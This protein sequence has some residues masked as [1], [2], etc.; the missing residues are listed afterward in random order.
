V[1]CWA[2]GV[3]DTGEIFS[4]RLLGK[5]REKAPVLKCTFLV[6]AS[7]GG[8]GPPFRVLEAKRGGD[9]L[10]ETRP[11]RTQTHV[12]GVG[13]RTTARKGASGAGKAEVGRATE[14][15][16]LLKGKVP[17]T[18]GSRADK[19]SAGALFL[20]AQLGCD[21]RVAEQV[22][23]KSSEDEQKKAL[24]G[25][26]KGSGC[27]DFAQ[28]VAREVWSFGLAGSAGTRNDSEARSEN[29]PE[30]FRL[31]S[32]QERLRELRGYSLCPEGGGDGLANVP[33][34]PRCDLSLGIDWAE[35]G[36]RLA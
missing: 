20:G 8:Q 10:G 33:N 31:V 5:E 17:A 3:R 32:L 6:W 35:K 13:K 18:K 2:G 9:Y 27:G 28:A 11:L 36:G 25:A 34:P 29:S 12:P 24:W 1:H 16:L 30:S 14:P 7:R 4:Q 21:G 22:D 26:V 23:V 19:T 15:P